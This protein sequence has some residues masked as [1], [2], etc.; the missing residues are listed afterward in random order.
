MDGKHRILSQ[1]YRCTF[2]VSV[3]YVQRHTLRWSVINHFEYAGE[4]CWFHAIIYSVHMLKSNQVP[5]GA[6]FRK[7]LDLPL[8]WLN[9]SVYK[10]FMVILHQTRSCLT[11]A[12]VFMPCTIWPITKKMALSPNRSVTQSFLIELKCE[13]WGIYILGCSSG[14]GTCIPNMS[15]LDSDCEKL[16]QSKDPKNVRSVTQSVWHS[17]FLCWQK[18]MAIHTWCNAFNL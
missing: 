14:A 5:K 15:L 7:I 10:Y 1:H 3:T 16:W 18:H 12:L 2:Y 13:R 17:T 8:I 6:P 11:L 9:I 4:W